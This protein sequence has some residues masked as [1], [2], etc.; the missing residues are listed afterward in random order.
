MHDLS[1]D[2]C[3]VDQWLAGIDIMD[4]ALVNHDLMLVGIKVYRHQFG[5]E[6]LLPDFKRRI[7]QFTQANIFCLQGS[8]FLHLGLLHELLR[9]QAVDLFLQFAA[10]GQ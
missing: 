10:A 9:V 7:E 2:P 6:Y 1:H 5:N 3:R 8:K 4:L